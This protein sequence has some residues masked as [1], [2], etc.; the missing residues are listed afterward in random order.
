MTQPA[1]PAPGYARPAPAPSFDFSSDQV[2]RWV[3]VV[4]VTLAGIFFVST[5]I[6]RGWISPEAQLVAATAGGLGLFA[7]AV[8][9]GDRLRQWTLPFALAG[10]TVISACAVAASAWLDIIS[11]EGAL[12][13]SVL[14]AAVSIGF[15]LKLRMELVAL[16]AGGL[17]LAAPIVGEVVRD[18]NQIVLAAW[19]VSILLG[20]TGLGVWQR[21][22]LVRIAVGWMSASVFAGYA[23]VELDETGEPIRSVTAYVVLGIISVTLWFAPILVRALPSYVEK[24]NEFYR[25]EQLNPL[26]HRLV[27]MV[28][29]GVWL[30]LQALTGQAD[31]DA[32]GITGLFIAAG[33][34]VLADHLHVGKSKLMYLSQILGCSAVVSVAMAFLFDGS[35][36]M[37]A[38]ASQAIISAVVADRFNDGPMKVWTG[39]VGIAATGLAIYGIADN[40]WDETA[41]AGEALAQ[42]FVL[43]V[44]AAATGMAFR[45]RLA[46]A[47]IVFPA[48]W[49][50]AMAWTASV[51]L[52][53]VQGQ[54]LLSLIWAV[55]AVAA[56]VVGIRFDERV[57]RNVGYANLAVVVGKL[58]TIDLAEVDVFWRV[59]LFLVV[60]IGFL[61]FAFVLPTLMK[62]WGVEALASSGNR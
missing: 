52:P 21:W 59:G 60:G 31:S 48:L 1:A 37:V 47:E 12:I 42:L 8:R 35:I 30:T 57:I 14:A 15:S 11:P 51:S 41:P 44:A 18:S 46:L 13:A 9:F 39:V 40:L 55:G 49:V 6:S 61:R 32:R 45:R 10:A 26:D 16:A 2:L 23:L 27:A 38:L 24:A 53:V 43:A 58:L 7:I 22:P 25:T 28:P 36:L 17:A 4:L 20:A 50:G 5:A 29:A 54:A 3:G 33:F 34:S 19:I 56:V 62:R